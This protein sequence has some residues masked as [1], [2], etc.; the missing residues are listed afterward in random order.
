M[1]KANKKFNSKQLAKDLI[2]KRYAAGLT[3]KDLSN[4]SKIDVNALFRAESAKPLT[5]ENLVKVCNW[6]DVPIQNYF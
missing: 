4:K 6:L 5:V 2:Q 3:Y 1:P